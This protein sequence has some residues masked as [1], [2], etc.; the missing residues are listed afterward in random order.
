MTAA[1]DGQTIDTRP[2]L[3]KAFCPT[4]MTSSM[5]LIA[6]KLAH[7]LKAFEGMA[8]APDGHAIEVRPLFRKAEFPT[9]VTPSMPVTLVMLPQSLKAFSGMA[10][11]VPGT[12]KLPL[13]EQLQDGTDPDDPEQ[14][15]GHAKGAGGTG[16]GEAG[17]GSEGGGAWVP[18]HEWGVVE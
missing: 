10:L 13:A 14:L 1:F 5:P 3:E 2:V 17:G 8:K 15:D 18:Y 6:V 9:L 7:D 16:G 12:K 4:L 11:T